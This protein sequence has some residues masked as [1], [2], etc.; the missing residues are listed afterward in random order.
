MNCYKKGNYFLETKLKTFIHEKIIIQ[1][2]GFSKMLVY[3]QR[4][5]TEF[6]S[7]LTLMMKEYQKASFLTN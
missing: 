6:N 2:Q 1:L 7:S 5:Q 4:D 3:L